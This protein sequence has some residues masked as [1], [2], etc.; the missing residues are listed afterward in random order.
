MKPI[1]NTKGED[2]AVTALLVKAAT[3]TC[4]LVTK[5]RKPDPGLRNQ[6]GALVKGGLN[7]A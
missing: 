1:E 2:R 3:L 4:G 6:R 7:H 5:N